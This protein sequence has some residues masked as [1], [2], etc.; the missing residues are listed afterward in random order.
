MP[1]MGMLMAIDPT[2]CGSGIDCLLIRRH[3]FGFGSLLPVKIT[4]SLAAP[5]SKLVV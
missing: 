4:C 1:A 2:R 3:E 5:G